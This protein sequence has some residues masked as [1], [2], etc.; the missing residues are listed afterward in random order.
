VDNGGARLRLER[1]PHA[2]RLEL[3]SITDARPM[4]T[5]GRL[6]AA[7]HPARLATEATT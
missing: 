2:P 3:L 7:A 1:V 6:W 5:L 4:S